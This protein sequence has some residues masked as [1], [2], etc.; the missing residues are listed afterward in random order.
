[1]TKRETIARRICTLNGIDPD[2][3]AFGRDGNGPELWQM[4]LPFI[5]VVLEEIERPDAV[6]DTQPYAGPTICGEESD[7]A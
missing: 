1:M 5:D 2:Q 3:R 7:G 4:Y 6:A